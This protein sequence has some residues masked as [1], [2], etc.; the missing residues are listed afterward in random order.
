MAKFFESNPGF[1]SRITHHIDFPDY[2]NPELMRIAEIMLESQNYRFDAEARSA[3]EDYIAVRRGQSH[4]ANARSIR[5]ALDRM[6]LR[7]ANRVFSAEGPIG[8]DDLMTL[9]GSDIRAS[10]VFAA[11]SDN[12]SPTR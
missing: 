6:R 4:F 12:L 10:R 3:F 1:R 7:L 2:S 9:R 5:N 8:R 11:S